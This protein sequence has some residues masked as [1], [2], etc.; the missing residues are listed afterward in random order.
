MGE[1]E[2]PIQ[3]TLNLKYIYLGLC[4]CSSFEPAQQPN[5][6]EYR[7]APGQHRTKTHLT[8]SKYIRSD[9]YDIPI[10]LSNLNLTV[11]KFGI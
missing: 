2:K 3:N 5:S 10:P 7:G 8:C 11:K 1:K 4:T 6:S 9:V